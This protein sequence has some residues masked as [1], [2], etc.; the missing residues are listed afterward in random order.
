MFENPSRFIIFLASITLLFIFAPFFILGSNAYVIYTDN[1]DSDF[2]FLHVLKI[3]GMLFHGDSNAIVPNIMNGLP[4]VY[5][6]SEFSFIRVLFLLLPSFWA[7]IINSIIV[8]IIGFTGMYLLMRDFFCN[9]NKKTAGYIAALFAIIPLYTLYGLSVAGVPI[10]LWSFLLILQSKQKWYHYLI[11]LLFPFYSHFALIGPFLIVLLLSIAIYAK[12]FS[13]FKVNSIYYIALVL[14]FCT[15]LL[16][17]YHIIESYV[18]PNGVLSHRSEWNAPPYAIK[19]AFKQMIKVFLFGHIHSTSFLAIPIYILGLLTMWSVRKDRR[20]LLNLTIPFVLIGLISIFMALYPFIKYAL[21]DNLHIITTFQ[22]T[23]F[24]FLIPVMWFFIIG[25]SVKYSTSDKKY[26]PIFFAIQ[27]I[28]IVVAN[29]EIKNNYIHLLTKGPATFNFNGFN[30][31]FSQ[32]LYK[33]VKTYIGKDPSTYK[34]VSLGIEPT[35]ALYNGFYTLDS[36]QN[37]YPLSYKHAFRHIIEKELGKNIELMERFDTWGNRCYLFSAELYECCVL[38]C[39]KLKNC[40]INHLEINVKALKELGGS[41][42]FSA[43]PI[44]NYKQLGVEFLDKFT[45]PYS[46]FNIY[47]YKI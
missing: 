24:S 36:Y 4:R 20:K 12:I 6:H 41:Y 16:A 15:F 8:R 17:N 46:R 26:I 7:Y 40:E 34:V 28:I 25:L 30:A 43:V 2:I 1:L 38:D 37:Y 47:L 9:G 3:S 33:E 23:R 45:S 27:A 5:F 35:V 19:V 44:N 32:D 11:I 39:N 18:F 13:F 31:V 29:K 42:I 21:R 22:L 10:I 14:L